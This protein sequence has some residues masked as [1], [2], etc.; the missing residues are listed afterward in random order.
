MERAQDSQTEYA[1]LTEFRRWV[2]LEWFNMSHAPCKFSRTV[3]KKKK[4]IGNWDSGLSAD[5]TQLIYEKL[6][7]IEHLPQTKAH[8]TGQFGINSILV[9]PN[10]FKSKDHFFFQMH[11]TCRPPSCIQYL[12]CHGLLTAFIW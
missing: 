4:T 2:L 9:I 7:Q 1:F 6:I 3:F 12:N 8:K 10:L 5:V 11:I